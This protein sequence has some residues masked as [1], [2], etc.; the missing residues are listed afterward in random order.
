M[1][2]S[3][4]AER[5]QIPPTPT[6]YGCDLTTRKAAP[7]RARHHPTARG[8]ACA[9]AAAPTP[10][11]ARTLA[12]PARAAGGER[13]SGGPV[14]GGK[15]MV[16]PG[17]VG[18][19]GGPARWPSEEEVRGWRHCAPTRARFVRVAGVA[20]GVR[21]RGRR[22]CYLEGFRGEASGRGFRFC[23]AA[24][25]SL[26]LAACVCVYAREGAPT[27]GCSVVQLRH[28]YSIYLSVN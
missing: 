10:A 24:S 4:T 9:T 15:A 25:Y 1:R 21:S 14:V 8:R 19:G 2:A 17:G 7:A 12:A 3:S 20:C 16:A 27:D 13:A 22:F 11:P 18:G 5:M 23:D 26:I 6:T 28:Q